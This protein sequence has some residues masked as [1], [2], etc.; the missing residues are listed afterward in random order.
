MLMVKQGAMN[1]LTL[2][3][4]RGR[5]AQDVKVKA[6][7]SSEDTDTDC[8]SEL[9]TPVAKLK[10]SKRNPSLLCVPKLYY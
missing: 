3:E 8:V 9:D 5:W 4:G 2:E 7:S 6:S 1:P 10:K